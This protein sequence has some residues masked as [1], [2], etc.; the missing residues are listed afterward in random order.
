VRIK[1]T[2]CI[3]LLALTLAGT[4]ALADPP[5]KKPT[6]PPPEQSSTVG[7]LGQPHHD[8][9]A[10]ALP[11]E[12]AAPLA[13][14]EVPKVEAEPPMPS[15]APEN[16]VVHPEDGGGSADTSGG[17]GP[18]MRV[19]MG[20]P[21]TGFLPDHPFISGIVAG[22]VGTDLG[23]KLYGGPMMGDQDG[24]VIGYAVRFGAILLVAWLVFRM[25]SRRASGINEPGLAPP[26]RR[27][28]TFGRGA[29]AGAV[30]REPTFSR[31]DHHH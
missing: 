13:A 30:R 3:A 26:G 4:A 15:A 5:R 28:P 21:P 29:D 20:P 23:S 11:R 10:P 7:V 25:I 9:N 27:E 14:P 1:F 22:L 2:F 8:A 19:P 16:Y 24:V 6:Y 31:R 17:S 18:M 12:P